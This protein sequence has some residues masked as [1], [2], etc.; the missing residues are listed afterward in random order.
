MRVLALLLVLAAG[1][2]AAASELAPALRM[3]HFLLDRGVALGGYDPV[4]YF[5]SAPRK[6]LDAF[7]ATHEGIEYRFASDANRRAFLADPARYETTYG[8]W[9]AWAMLDGEKVEPDPQA[10]KIV[11]GRLLLFYDGLLGNTLARWNAR[12]AKEGDAHLV[13]LADARWAELA[14]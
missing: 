6:G 11:D 1:A 14:R 3:R 5:A 12:A 7:V 13:A 2:T 8:G 10:Y 9:C 4:S